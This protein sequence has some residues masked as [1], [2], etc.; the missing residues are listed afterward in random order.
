MPYASQFGQD[1]FLDRVVYRGLRAG[2]FVDVGAHDGEQ[3]S[4]SVFFER[5]RGWRGLCIEPNPAV[6]AQLRQAR[7]ADC[8]QCCIA[9]Q[10]G[11]VEFLQVTGASEMLSGMVSTYPPE[12]RERLLRDTAKDQGTYHVIAVPALPLAALLEARDAR[13]I[14]LL[15]IDIEGG[16]V[17]ALRS[18][19]F[20]HC[21]VHAVSI[22]N[23]YRQDG[24]SDR[25]LR[26]QGF[27]PLV[28]LA[29]DTVYLN[30]RSLF[31]SRA[32]RLRCLALRAAARIERKLR[33]LGMLRAGPARFPYKAP[34]RARKGRSPPAPASGTC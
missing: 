3:Y 4:N 29:V 24:C 17:E 22:E 27:V 8:V 20:A 34:H 25:M 26:D 9:A 18:L 19:D 31:L 23:N 6:F 11:S 16:E 30:R 2:Y 33:K 12:H 1:E 32:L 13:E 28:R 14:H 10:R 15:S 7:R 5:E 21:F